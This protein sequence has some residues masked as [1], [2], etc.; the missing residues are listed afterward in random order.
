M[1]GLAVNAAEIAAKRVQL[2]KEAV[3]K[4]SRVA[5]LWNSSVQSMALGFQMIE[6]AAP[7][8][9]VTVQSVRVSGSD[10]FDQAFTAIERGHPGG[11]IVL[12]G[13]LR[14]NDLPRIVEFVAQHRIPT[15]FELGQGVRGR[16]LME[17]GPSQWR[18]VRR[19]A[20]YID[21]IANG[22]HP[23]DLPVEELTVFEL[24]INLKAARTMGI[25]IPAALL[26]RA[27]R[28]IE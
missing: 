3:P 27:D 14:G 11:L 7:T 16:G 9:G 19:G 17:F 4:F 1:T 12:F 25:T 10:E 24:V 23:E 28:V 5:V 2:L 13:P 20:A 8:L 26:Q 6:Q 15:I 18:M 22:A 21:K